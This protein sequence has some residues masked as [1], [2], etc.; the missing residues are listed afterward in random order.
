MEKVVHR[1]ALY[2]M[3][4]NKVGLFMVIAFYKEVAAA[5]AILDTRIYTLSNLEN[6]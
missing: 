5:T 4:S 2:F 1:N 6:K 3:H